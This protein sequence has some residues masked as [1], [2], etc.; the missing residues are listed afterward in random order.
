MIVAGSLPQTPP[1]RHDAPQVSGCTL[2][3]LTSHE[4]SAICTAPF[5]K[6]GL[7][8][9]NDVVVVFWRLICSCTTT[10]TPTTSNGM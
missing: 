5:D 7:L 8:G 1:H 4:P 6:R 10:T 2:S 3:E 9:Y